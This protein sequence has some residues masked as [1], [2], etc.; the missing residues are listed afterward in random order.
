MGSEAGEEKRGEGRRERDDGGDKPNIIIS[1]I[2]SLFLPAA[3][4]LNDRW[5]HLI[6]GRKEHVAPIGRKKLGKK[7]TKMGAIS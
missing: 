7:R 5:E 4:R 3:S 6:M 2:F 1:S